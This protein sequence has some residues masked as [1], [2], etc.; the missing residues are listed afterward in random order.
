[1]EQ[2]WILFSS[3]P[4]SK[5]FLLCFMLPNPRNDAFLWEFSPT[6]TTPDLNLLIWRNRGAGSC[7]QSA[8]RHIRYGLT[9]ALPRRGPGL[10]TACRSHSSAPTWEQFTFYFYFL[11]RTK[12]ATLMRRIWD[13]DLWLQWLGKRAHLSKLCM[14]ISYVESG[15]LNVNLI[16][17]HGN[18]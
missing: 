18:V 6:L 16:T 14:P 12:Q 15:G 10:V 3:F 8:E 4:I 13:L 17:T 9:K 5:A 1:M 2:D 11:E 7:P